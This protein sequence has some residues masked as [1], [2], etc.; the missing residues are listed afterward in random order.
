MKTTPKPNAT[1][2]SKGELV[3]PVPPPPPPELVVVVVAAGGAIE[4]GD[5]EG[6]TSIEV[7]EGDAIF[8]TLNGLDQGHL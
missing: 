6:V 8:P 3:G 2:K 4:V 1:K 5:K 7:D